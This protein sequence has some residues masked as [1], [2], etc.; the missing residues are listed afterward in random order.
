MTAASTQPATA[1]EHPGSDAAPP[2][3]LRRRGAGPP[4]T[5]VVASVAAGVL[6]AAPLLYLLTSLGN[7]GALTDLAVDGA[8]RAAV[9]RTVA[10]A[11]CCALSTAVVGT[12][13]AWLTARSDAPGRRLLGPILILPL[14][15]PS[16]VGA[17]AL[18]ATVGTGGLTGRWL[19]VE[20]PGLT[21]GFGAAWLVLTLFTFPY[22]SL[23]VSARLAGLPP[24]LEES[25]RV[26]GRSPLQ[27]FL[28]VVLP[29]IRPA[30]LAGALLVALY[31]LGEF[32]AVSVLGVDTL[33][34]LIAAD[35]L[36]DPDRSRALALV[37]GALALAVVALERRTVT[38]LAAR[39]TVSARHQPLTVSLRRY[40]W[41]A[42]ALLGALGVVALAG[43]VAG[44]LWWISRTSRSLE[45]SSLGR[46]LL[47]TALVAVLAAA[48]AVLITFPLARL[49][50]RFR[51]PAGE[52]IGLIVVAGYALP[53]LV[54]A[55][56]V[57]AVGVDLP[58]MG[59]LNRSAPA[60]L[61]AYVIHF[62]AEATRASQVAIG[63]VT[64]R[65]EDAARLL[66]ARWWRRFWEVE[67]PLV[68]PGVASGAG[69]VL[70]SVAKELPI[71][72]VAAPVGSALTGG[73][74][75]T[76]AT[77]V[78]AKQE[79]GLLAQAGLAA[80][81]LV[82]VS[83]ALTALLVIRPTPRPSGGERDRKRPSGGERDRKR[84]SGGERDAPSGRVARRRA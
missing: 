43:P 63:A 41:P 66:G 27:T 28:T 50:A 20:F 83:G 37:L 31:T 18:V 46:P 72:L 17:L 47:T 4:R 35:R 3:G 54:V 61:L 6:F 59:W 55:L 42:S 7:P 16:F 48:A 60:L 79:S 36:F 5:L 74:F 1:T 57:V 34:R 22:V 52:A 40:R 68:L 26:L 33:P 38:A 9:L 49:T 70:L 45:V 30:I 80:L 76:L 75:E 25:A 78:W 69:L 11:A 65:Y 62:G 53:G 32:G 71:T 81:A 77:R 56:S 19:G 12:A 64:T 51:S 82:A 67:A 21:R 15:V 2:S 39:P 58:G 10:L 73:R 84:P 8:A 24:S 23:P 29:Q 44:M 14:A 13:V